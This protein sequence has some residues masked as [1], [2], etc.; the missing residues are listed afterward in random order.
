MTELGNTLYLHAIN[1][2]SYLSSIGAPALAYRRLPDTLLMGDSTPGGASAVAAG[3]TAEARHSLASRVDPFATLRTPLA[4]PRANPLL[5][6]LRFAGCWHGRHP[7][8][9]WSMTTCLG[10]WERPLA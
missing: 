9:R 1:T 2:A 10:G 8:L 7:R 3:S 5:A 4:F 6:P